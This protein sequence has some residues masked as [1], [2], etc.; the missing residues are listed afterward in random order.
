EG[1]WLATSRH[2]GEPDGSALP[3]PAAGTTPCARVRPE[4]RESAAVSF[5]PAGPCCIAPRARPRPSALAAPGGVRPGRKAWSRCK[6]AASRGHQVVVRATARRRRAVRR[7][8]ARRRHRE[9]EA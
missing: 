8:T 3:C 9:P 7:P 4:E 5:L 1:V 2:G 6:A